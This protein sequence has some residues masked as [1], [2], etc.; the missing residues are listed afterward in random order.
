[1]QTIMGLDATELPDYT[2][3]TDENDVPYMT[4][5]GSWVRESDLSEEV[6]ARKYSPKFPKQVRIDIEND[7]FRQRYDTPPPRG[8]GRP[9]KEG[10]KS[11]KKYNCIKNEEKKYTE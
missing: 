5:Y 2:C 8:R 1:M 6:V 10:G 7:C 3:M 11:R 9:P 4:L